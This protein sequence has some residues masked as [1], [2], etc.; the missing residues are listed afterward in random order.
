MEF[1][2]LRQ[3]YL[4][5]F[6]HFVGFEEKPIPAIHAPHLAAT[7]STPPS[8]R[9]TGGSPARL[10]P[11][12]HD[13]TVASVLTENGPEPKEG[14]SVV[15][16]ALVANCGTAIRRIDHGAVPATFHTGATGIRTFRI[17]HRTLWIVPI[18]IRAPL[19]HIPM[20]IVESPRIRLLLPHPM[21]ITRAV[22]CIPPHIL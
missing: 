4:R 22:V 10:P 19:T 3:N 16:I 17:L 20:H 2:C 8:P 21:R 15:W 18:P 1:H 11:L 7:T 14:V 9:S 12:I 6:V 13:G 5:S